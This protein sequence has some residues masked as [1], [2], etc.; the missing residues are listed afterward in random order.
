MSDI[1]RYEADAGVATITLNRPESMNA[2]TTAL[3]ADLFDALERAGSDQSARAVVVTGE[4]R[5]FS[6]GADLKDRP[7]RSVEEILQTE[8]RPVLEKIASL[9]TRPP[10]SACRSPL[11]AIC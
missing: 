4:G 8:Y 9:P 1:V 6:A 2:F 3:R 10:G 11:P 7:D 5:C